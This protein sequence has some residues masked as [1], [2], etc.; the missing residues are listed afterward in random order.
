MF[1]K[2]FNLLLL[3]I[4]STGIFGQ[5]NIDSTS[6][7]SLS[8]ITDPAETVNYDSTATSSDSQSVLEHEVEYDAVDSILFDLKNNTVY[9]YGEA[10]VIY[11]DITLTANQISYNFDSYSVVAIGGVDSSGKEM[12]KPF[13]KQGKEEFTAKKITY[14]FESQKGYIQEVRTEVADAYVHAKQSKKQANNHVHI[15]GGYFTTCDKEK[16]H[17]GFKTT[18]MIVIPDDKIVTGPGY[19]TFFN[20]IPVPIALPFALIPNQ[21]RNASG[22][23]LP[24]YGVAQA[25]N[26]GFYLKDGGY[27]W[28]INDYLHMAFKASI[29]ANGSW[30]VSN[31]TEY[32]ARYKF[33]GNFKIRY[34]DYIIGDK[35][36][37]ASSTQLTKSVTINW[38][39]IQDTKAS[40]NSNFNANVNYAAGSGNRYNLSATDQQYINKNINSTI[41]YKYS[42]PNSPFNLSLNAR[43]SQVINEYSTDTT[44]LSTT[45]DISLPQLTFN[46]TRIDL[47]LSFLR[48]NK[49]GGKKWF[50]KIGANYTMNA[51]NRL[52][53]NQQQLDS[54]KLTPDNFEQYL[55]I[56]NGIKHDASLSTS[57]K[58][59]TFSV[60]PS[61]RTN[62]NWYF[63]HLNKYLDPNDLTEQTDTIK[64][65]SQVWNIS[66]GINVTGKLYGM[67]SFKGDKWIKAM[68]HQV[69]GSAG[70]NYS[71]G[72]STQEY[73]YVGDDGAFVSYNPYEGSIYSPP[74]SRPT[75]IYNFR[76]IN[77]L[78]A[79][80]K[81]KTD[82][83][84][85][86]KK[87]K[88]INNLT[89]DASFDALADSIKWTDIR[90]NGRF[91]KLF[92]ALDINYNA[93][94]D[95]YSYDEKAKKTNTS[96]YTETGNLVRIKSAGLTASF[97]LKSKKKEKK[98]KATNAAELAIQKE[99]EEDPGMFQNLNIPW[100]VSFNYN[101][102]VVSTPKSSGDMLFF[103]EK[104]NNT[105]GLRGSFT[106]F[107]IF[108]FS[109]NTGYDFVNTDFSLTT[110]GL[111][112]DL[113]CWEIN[114]TLRPNGGRQSY[115]LSINVKSPLLKDLKIKREST[116]GGASGVF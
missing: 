79:K 28:S 39:H 46:M 24:T 1:S 34:E 38:S 22:I 17:F 3:I 80:V 56:R 95:P 65:F 103:D 47:P 13:F 11:G 9:L 107:K 50:E 75:N 21:N 68:R 108:R 112:V 78:E 71:P 76:L 82:S 60:S 29:F 30:D 6:V 57:F 45:N 77:D 44:T 116:F 89:M 40:P 49:S 14:N 27:Y 69:T 2:F 10:Q 70:V 72:V 99:Y 86:F 96:W 81:S 104:I 74:S 43:M 111:Y 83:T 97:S 93:I 90:M 15:K 109:V 4:I 62:G 58:V 91:T 26:Q 19:L 59:K 53:F 115:S 33:K 32:A 114:A 66:G 84:E 51:E 31:A 42:I 100:D 98:I 110:L 63:R 20:V 105:L 25:Y 101:I 5:S 106:V 16:P 18:R 54:I 67:Y 61:I 36:I 87:V 94:F 37:E 41:S 35:D 92:N 113:H 52:K 7:D 88:F 55:N 64:E 12:G 85:T 73:G 8:V 48:K 102:N 23:I